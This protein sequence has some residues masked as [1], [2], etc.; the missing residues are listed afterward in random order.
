MNEPLRK[1]VEVRCSVPHAFKTFTANIDAWWPHRR[2]E[3]STIAIEPREGGRFF[4]AAPSGEDIVHGHVVAWEPPHRLT[5]TWHPG[6]DVGPTTV[7]V[8]FHDDGGSTRVEIVHAEGDSGL[9]E[10]WL[11]R[12]TIFER[13]WGSVLQAFLDHVHS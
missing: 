13:A 3:G 8:T 2:H 11:D 5:Y 4:E 7:D 10:R 1:R 9:G 12:A 6:S